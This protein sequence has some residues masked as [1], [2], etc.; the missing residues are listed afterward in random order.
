MADSTEI[1]TIGGTYS[2][3]SNIAALADTPTDNQQQAPPNTKKN[4]RNTANQKIQP[5]KTHPNTVPTPL[6]KLAADHRA[7]RTT[8]RTAA[9][10]PTLKQTIAT[11][12]DRQTSEPPSLENR[13]KAS[14][15][16]SSNNSR[17]DSLS[18]DQVSHWK[19]HPSDPNRKV[20]QEKDTAP[21]QDDDTEWMDDGW[22]S[23]TPNSPATTAFKPAPAV[24][25]VAVLA[26]PNCY[27]AL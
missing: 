23:T 16:S 10:S 22:K 3:N 8:H 19:Y 2:S 14:S 5:A 9:T 24:T 1:N 11:N 15:S 17:D 25:Q 18:N 6:K 27:A 21:L 12:V 26:T 7:K 4:E 20:I 13:S